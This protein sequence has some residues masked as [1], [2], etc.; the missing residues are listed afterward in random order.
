MAIVTKYPPKCEG[1]ATDEQVRFAALA[2]VHATLH[3][4]LR[5]CPA[6]NGTPLEFPGSYPM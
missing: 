5:A 2:C 6:G 1:A 3:S 4:S